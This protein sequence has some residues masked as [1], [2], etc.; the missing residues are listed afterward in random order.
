MDVTV[1]TAVET[2]VAQVGGRALEIFRVVAEDGERDAGF[3]CRRYGNGVGN[4]QDE[5]VIT[6]DVRT[7]HDAADIHVRSLPGAFEVKQGAALLDGIGWDQM[8]AIPAVTAV[9]RR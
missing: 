6:A 5:F 3:V 7:D 9:V 8:G 4:V 1:E 2:E